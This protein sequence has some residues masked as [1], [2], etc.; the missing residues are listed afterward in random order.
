MLQ[1]LDKARFPDPP[2]R[3]GSK[4]VFEGHEMVICGYMVRSTYCDGEAYYWDEYLLYNPRVGF[5]WLVDSDGHWS[6]VEPVGVADVEAGTYYAKHQGRSYRAFDDVGSQVEF[7]LGQ[8]YWNVEP[9]ERV[10]M[11]DFTSP[12]YTLAEE[13]TAPKSPGP[14]APTCPRATSRSALARP[15]ETRPPG[16]WGL[17]SRI[18]TPAS[19]KSLACL[20]VLAIA[21]FAYG[22]TRAKS[23]VVLQKTFDFAAGA[24]AGP[25]AVF[26]EPFTLKGGRNLEF[27]AYSPVSN[28]WVYLQFDLINESTG[29]VT[30][31]DMPI[32]QYS[33]PD[34]KEGSSTAKKILKSV[35]S[36]EHTL[37]LGIERKQFS[38]PAHVK[39]I[40]REGVIRLRY[41]L[42]LLGLLAIIPGFVM[43][44]QKSFEGRRWSDSSTSQ[45][46]EHDYDYD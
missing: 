7:V 26:S 32:E 12:P 19:T 8:F 34:W 36:G 35:G 2:L 30:F 15:C 28:S 11:R 44:D 27:E 20:M 9:G 43:L 23:A 38:E 13:K 37:R 4:G 17:G 21:V 25:D 16:P 41:F 22:T 45:S 14:R 6:Y 18:R 39:L 40:V 3:L 1:I 24:A 33:G 46:W 10:E 29:A 31:F 5:R 42:I